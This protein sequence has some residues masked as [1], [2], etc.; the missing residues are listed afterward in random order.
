[1][2]KGLLNPLTW[3]WEGP[4]SIPKTWALSEPVS[5]HS[6]LVNATASPWQGMFHLRMV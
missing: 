6:D 2:A 1:M 3:D 4:K 5:F